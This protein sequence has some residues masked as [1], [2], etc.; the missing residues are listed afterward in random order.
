MNDAKMAEAI[1]N[2]A[3]LYDMAESLDAHLKT[4]LDVE[5]DPNILHKTKLVATVLI[6]AAGYLVRDYKRSTG[7][8]MPLPEA[9]DLLSEF[10][11]SHAKD[12]VM[13]TTMTRDMAEDILRKAG[14]KRK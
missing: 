7:N 10:G 5:G 3:Y 4:V 14:K 6:L 12:E 8:R 1:K 13:G 11:T 2:D 9:I